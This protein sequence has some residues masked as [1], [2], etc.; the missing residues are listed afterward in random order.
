MTKILHVTEGDWP[1]LLASDQPVLVDFW[2][3]WCPPCH[4]LA[5]VF[6]KLAARYGD[7][8]RFAKVNIDEFAQ[9][10]NQLGIRSIPTLVLFREG[11]EVERLVGVRPYEVLAA[12]LDHHVSVAATG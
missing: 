2:A 1:T 7:E 12:L 3:E 11:K 5:P 10:A 9:L 8:I 4:R 6:E